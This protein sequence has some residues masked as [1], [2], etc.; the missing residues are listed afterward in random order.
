MGLDPM[1]V[2]S[3]PASP[4]M[5]NL[6]EKI[7]SG[8]IK[9][10]DLVKN[11]KA[12]FESYRSGNLNYVTDDGF[13]FQIPIEDT[14][15]GSFMKEHNA[16]DLMRWIRKQ[17]ELI[18]KADNVNAEFTGNNSLDGVNHVQRHSILPEQ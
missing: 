2:G 4:T 10:G 3:K 14:G 6:V 16:L 15:N 17:M 7:K 8:E 9:T 12:Y 5:E 18:K 1:N 11:K 13:Q